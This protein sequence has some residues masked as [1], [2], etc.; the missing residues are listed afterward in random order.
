VLATA[1]GVAV[2]FGVIGVWS[3]LRRDWFRHTSVPLEAV[4]LAGVAA[5]VLRLL[6]TGRRHQP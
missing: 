5:Y 2:V 6:L 4:L 1:C 3:L